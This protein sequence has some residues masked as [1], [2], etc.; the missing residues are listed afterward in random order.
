MELGA[1][2]TPGT[3][4]CPL[5]AVNLLLLLRVGPAQGRFDRQ[6]CEQQLPTGQLPLNSLAAS[7]SLKLCDCM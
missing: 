1:V 6:V 7:V 2:G 4:D 3:V 5:L